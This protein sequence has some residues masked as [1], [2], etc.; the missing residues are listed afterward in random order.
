M[1]LLNFLRIRTPG[2]MSESSTSSGVGKT[3]FGDWA[4]TTNEEK[5]YF[6][7]YSFAKNIQGAGLIFRCKTKNSQKVLSLSIP[8]KGNRYF[9][10]PGNSYKARLLFGNSVV[11][12]ASLRAYQKKYVE[13]LDITNEILENMNDSDCIKIDVTGEKNA[14]VSVHFSLDGASTA[15][16][17]VIDHCQSGLVNCP[18]STS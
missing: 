10:E 18:A 16:S 2:R 13:F 5:G 17:S 9:F 7:A 14:V 3:N 11:L 1:G 12:Y 6:S 4:A 8:G 15:I